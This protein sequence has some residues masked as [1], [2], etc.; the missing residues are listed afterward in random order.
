MQYIWHVEVPDMIWG[1]D[2]QN[3]TRPPTPQMEEV[4]GNLES[5]QSE[6]MCFPHSFQIIL[7]GCKPTI[8][9]EQKFIMANLGGQKKKHHTIET[10][11]SVFQNEQIN[12]NKLLKLKTKREKK[13]CI[14]WTVYLP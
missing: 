14:V 8:F 7:D 6:G 1:C 12:T 4:E 5:L 3:N 11:Q 9:K 2:P 13:A 10:Q